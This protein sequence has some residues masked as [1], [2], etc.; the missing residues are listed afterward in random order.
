[1]M[2]DHILSN[3]FWA[4]F[5][6]RAVV[7]VLFFAIA[8]YQFARWLR[9]DSRLLLSFYGYCTTV[10]IA[11]F[12]HLGVIA[13]VLTLF[14]PAMVMVFIVLHQDTLQKK[15]VTIRNITPAQQPHD[16]LAV[17]FGTLLASAQKGKAA[18]VV[19]EKNDSIKSLLKS[20]F[21]LH[22]NVQKS[23]LDLLLASDLYD[24]SK[25]IWVNHH[26]QL[27]AINAVWNIELD[28]Q[29]ISEDVVDLPQWKQDAL[30][31]AHKTDALVVYL[32]PMSRC[33]DLVGQQKMLEGVTVAQAMI[34]VK[35]Y[36]F[37]NQPLVA[38]AIP[39]VRPPVT[40]QSTLQR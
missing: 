13:Q 16:W 33:V 23:L 40:Q 1:M 32:D 11:H 28:A 22:A 34:V 35:Q 21:P 19:I 2:I 31:L 12:F 26:G 6:W 29:W 30:L 7:E 27:L 8:L 25:L 10:V 14:A 37:G 18:Y 9:K 15:F 4:L 38:E 5:G 24:D 17:L 20:S 39:H 36:L 3:Y